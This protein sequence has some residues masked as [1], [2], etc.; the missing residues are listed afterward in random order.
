MKK[1]GGALL[2]HAL[3]QVGTEFTFGIP[4][5]HNTEIYDELNKSKQIKPILTTHEVGASF[6][7][8]GVSRTGKS[9]GV[10]VLV[11]AAGITHA[12]SGIAEA[13]LD[14]IPM[15]VITGGIRRD[16]GKAYQ[17]HDMNQEV[18]TKALVKGYFRPKTHSD[19]IPMAYQAY[20]LATSGLPGPVLFEMPGE[21]QLFHGEVEGMPN[22][23]PLTKEQ[24]FS[25]NDLNKAIELLMNAKKPGLY[26]GWGAKECAK[27]NIEMADCLNSPTA[28][29]LQGLSVFPASHPLHVGMG[30]G[31]SSSPA[32]QEAFKDCDCLLAVGV[33]FSELA[34]GSYGM[35]IPKNLIHVDIDPEV[36]NKNYPA[37]IT[38]QG[39]ASVIMP[40]LLAKLKEKETKTSNHEL[41]NKIAKLKKEYFNSWT[42]NKNDKLVSPGYFFKSLREHLDDDAIVV[43]DDGNH[44]FLTMELMPIY[45]PGSFI[46]P[47]DFNC[48]G[49]CIPATNAAKLSNPEKQVVGIVGDGALLMTGLEAMTATNQGLGVVY[50]IFSDGELGQISIFQKIPLNRKTCT[51][52]GEMKVKGI[53]DATGSHFVEMNNDF[54]IDES[55]MK[56]LELAKAGRPVFVDVKIDYSK[57]T[58]FSEGV[59]KTNLQRFALKDKV[60]IIGRAIKR[61]TLG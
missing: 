36:F 56:A 24:H 16:T 15:I 49:Y 58:K 42:K 28:T 37:K 31:K 35:D 38:L 20:S 57:K 51:V 2:V 30:F 50:F 4:G 7:A 43:A 13:M 19:I 26:L 5:V 33:R 59:I 53:A 44:T 10:C 46:S 22:Y 25:E 1:S 18:M 52:L 41:K 12:A 55:M 6:M 32:A 45:K 29:T 27:S 40:R 17:L 8:D 60:R 34:T 21:L 11:P 54:D 39:D 14:G 61:H 48:M 9:V 3:E 23:T 47:S